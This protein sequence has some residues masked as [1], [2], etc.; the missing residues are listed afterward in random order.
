M[1]RDAAEAASVTAVRDLTYPPVVMAVKTAFRALGIRFDLRGTEHVPTQGGAVLV[2]NHVSY[3]D[4]M[5]GGY[6][7]AA[8]RRLVRFMSKRELF[9]HRLTGPLMRS[10]HHIEVDRGAGARLVRHGGGVPRRR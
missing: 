1:R 3:V 6:A 10:L 4:F 8:G 9:D 2:L 7:A 5:F